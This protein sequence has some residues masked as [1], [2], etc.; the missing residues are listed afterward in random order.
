MKLRYAIIENEELARRNLQAQIEQARPGA[1]MLFY[2]ETIEESIAAIREHPE[3]SLIF[4][5]IELDDGNCFEIFRRVEVKAPVV[6]TTAYDEYAIK[7]FKVNSI[8]YL[9]KP[10]E[11]ADVETAIAKFEMRQAPARD[12]AAVA[13]TMLPNRP[14]TRV[15]ITSG[16][17]YGYV[18]VADIAWFEAEEKYVFVVMEGGK[19]KLTGLASLAD[20]S[21]KMDADKFFQISRSVVTSVSAIAK[22]SKFFKGRL[23]VELRTGDKTR[24]EMV[25]AARRD[26]FLAWLGEGN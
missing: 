1:Q 14:R 21:A 2:C 12:Y 11:Q 3:V 19:R 13:E 10:I 4:M 16:T 9:L 17:D 5:D 23:V 7:A 26:D 8:D 22:V 25:S 6:F 18:N 24:K 20:V 15:L